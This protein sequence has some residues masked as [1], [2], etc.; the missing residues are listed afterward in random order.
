MQATDQKNILQPALFLDRDGVINVDLDYVSSCEEFEFIDGIFDLC[1]TA[2]Q[3]GYLIFVVTNQA[4]IGRGYYNEQDFLELTN[5]MCDVFRGEGVEISKVYYCPY[6]PEHGVGQYKLDSPNRKPKPGMI[7]EAIKEFGVDVNR[8]V[9]IG[10]N[11]TDVEA[12]IAAGVA[13]N[14]LFSNTNSHN[15]ST[16]KD[17]IIV[18]TL[19]QAK[20]FLLNQ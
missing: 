6:H 13:N 4:G 11:V 7:L 17:T 16:Y 8:S 9:L 15:I 14:I 3:L 12:G 20:L 19:E 2:R 5:W 18:N 10:N 1:R